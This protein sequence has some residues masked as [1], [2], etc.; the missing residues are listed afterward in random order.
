MAADFGSSVFG[1]IEVESFA[2]P[3][4]FHLARYGHPGVHFTLIRAGDPNP[5]SSSKASPL[6]WRFGPAAPGANPSM[7]SRRGC[8]GWGIN[9]T[10]RLL[11]PC[12]SAIS[13]IV[14]DATRCMWLV[15]FAATSVD[16]SAATH[17]SRWV[18]KRIGVV[19]LITEGD[20]KRAE[21]STLT[22]T[23]EQF[24]EVMESTLVL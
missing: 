11:P 12:R 7:R 13:D 17:F 5:R 2:A 16:P 1:P 20:L 15:R 9:C 3:A 6:S 4:G 23:Q 22:D 8:W 19:G 18:K 14:P 24:T 10:T 21:P